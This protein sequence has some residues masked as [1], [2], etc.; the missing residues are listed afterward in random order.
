MEYPLEPGRAEMTAYGQA[1]AEFVLRFTEGL[2]AAPGTGVTGDRQLRELL[3]RPPDEGPGDLADLL[4]VFGAAA[5]Q[6]VETAGPGYLAYIPGGGLYVSALA[7]FLARSVNRFTGLAGL[8]PELVA[9][10]QGILLWLCREFGLPPAAGGLVTTG[11]SIATLAA[12][13]AARHHHLG[14][15]FTAGT[16][17]LTEHSHH[18]IAKAA[19]IAGF[20]AARVRVVPTSAG[21]RMDTGAAAR[22]IAADRRAGLRPFL[23]VGNAGTTNTGAVDP[24][25]ELAGLAAREGLWFH[26]DGAY[27]G[28]FQLTGRGK[29]A[30]AGIGAADSIVLD[31]HKGM[32]LPYGTGVLLVRDA[33]RLA[34]AHSG[35]AHYLQDLDAETVLPDFASLGPE[36]T[37]E[38]RGL[39]LWLPLR[40]HGAAAFRAALDEKL[41]LA[42]HAYQDLAADPALEV[43][44]EPALSTLAFRL[45]D[46]D[47]DANLAFLDR[48]N[49][50]GRVFLSSTR[51]GGRVMLRL[52][53]LSHRTHREHVDEALA[54]IRHE[55]RPGAP[56]GRAVG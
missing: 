48:V 29:A 24:L 17:Y 49:R 7:E 44:W 23:L 37:R 5:G 21:L 8:A 6:A 30:L 20:P 54:V 26:A 53:I 52:C 36:L 4:G 18:C 13:V 12:V 19:R 27:G 22:L 31:P 41:D 10:E 2:Q 14:E 32:F 35:E 34:A 40:L 45:R 15:D 43:P 11:G 9:M 56:H 39:P 16:I 46:A 28:C 33:G 50:A 25:P 38:F 55:A 42:R 3:L 51:I 47:D 1:A